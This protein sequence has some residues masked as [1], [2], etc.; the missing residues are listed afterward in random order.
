MFLKLTNTNGETVWYNF[1]RVRKFHSEQ[2]PHGKIATVL[3][4]DYGTAVVL[5]T[6]EEIASMLN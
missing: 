6:P 3:D 5:E 4:L 2:F 1:D